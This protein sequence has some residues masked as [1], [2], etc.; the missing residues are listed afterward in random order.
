MGDSPL[1]LPAKYQSQTAMAN[2]VSNLV[3]FTTP[4][5]QGGNFN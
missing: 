5:T 4:L 1:A 2:Q 3:S